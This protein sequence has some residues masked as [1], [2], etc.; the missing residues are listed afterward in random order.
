MKHKCFQVAAVVLTVVGLTAA[1]ALSQTFTRTHMHGH[2]MFGGSMLGF[3]ARALNLTEDQRSQMK[4]VM[5][6]EKP[7][8]KPLFAQL[9]TTR[10]QVRQLEMSDT[11]DEAKVREVAT[12]QAQAMTELT[13]QQARIH[14]EL[15]QLLTPDQKAKL[16]QMMQQRQQR[17]Q[18]HLQ[19]QSPAQSQ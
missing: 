18:E 14:S 12:Q 19:Q 3:H 6:K 7:A 15:Y 2:G 5:A 4:S 1:V 13:V 17:I 16:T 10:Q 9:A 8:L 11:F